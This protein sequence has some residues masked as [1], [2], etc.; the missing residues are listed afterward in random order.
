M[1][2]STIRPALKRTVGHCGR[3]LFF[4]LLLWP[5]VSFA[6]L[7]LPLLDSPAGRSPSGI[8]HV[9]D[10]PIV[11]D[12]IGRRIER[13]LSFGETHSYVL[14]P[15]LDQYV[16]LQLEGFHAEVTIA[17]RL[18]DGR[19]LLV[20]RCKPWTT[21]DLPIVTRAAGTHTVEVRVQETDSHPARYVLTL[22]SL[23]RATASDGFALRAALAQAEAQELSKLWT[24]ETTAKALDKYQRAFRD[25]MTARDPTCAIRC[26]VG[27]TECLVLLGRYQ[28]AKET[29][30]Q[31]ISL[32]RQYNAPR[33]EA[34]ALNGLSA[35]DNIW[36][37][38]DLAL[39]Y[40]NQAMTVAGAAAYREGVARAC[41]NIG[42]A[43]ALAGENLRALESYD[44]AFQIWNNLENLPGVAQTL[45][46][47]GYTHA[48]L[49]E[50]DRAKEC[51]QQALDAWKTLRD[52]QGQAST[53]TAL[54]HLYSILGEKQ[55]ALNLYTQASEIL[56]SLGEP[57]ARASML[58]GL[59]YVYYELD[60]K[61]RA[62]EY[63]QEALRVF[64]SIRYRS[65]EGSSLVW[66]ATCH[67]ALGNHSLAADFLRQALNV[68]EA[69]P[70]TRMQAWLFRVLGEVHHALGDD[71]KALDY[72]RQALDLTVAS[73]NTREQGYILD[74]IADHYFD[75]GEKKRAMEFSLQALELHRMCRDSFG[76]AATLCNLAQAAR[77]LGDLDESLARLQA[78]VGIIES[79]R[80][81]VSVQGLRVSYFASIRRHYD[82]YI[83]LLMRLHS[84]RPGERY[85]AAALQVSERAR[86]RNLLD[87]LSEARA[88]IRSGADPLLLERER[89]LRQALNAKAHQQMQV[90]SRG[91]AEHE[92]EALAKEIGDLNSQLELVE[93]QIR[94]RS[95]RYAALTL[96]LPL[97][98]PQIEQN[99]L[100]KDTLLL[101]YAL[102]DEHSY[103]WAVTTET[104]AG[105]QLPPRMAIEGLARKAYDLLI[106]RQKREAGEPQKLWHRRM[107]ESDSEYWKAASDL[108][109]VLLGPVAAKLGR[110]RLLI[111]SE[112]MLQYLPFAALPVPTPGNAKS[113]NDS[114][115]S[116]RTPLVLEHEIVH[117]PSAST[118]AVL[119]RE[120]DGRKPGEGGVV[121]F[122]DPV[123]EKE[124]PRVEVNKP[125]V[126]R[127]L[128]Q[129]KMPLKAG[130]SSNLSGHVP[131]KSQASPVHAE[132][133]LSRLFSTRRE[134]E[135]VMSVVPP[136]EGATWMDFEADRSRAT[137]LGLMQYRIVHFA[138][139]GIL[140][141]MNPNLSAI[142][143]C[144]VD[145]QGHPKDGLL[146]LHDIYNLRLSAELVVLSAC[147]TALGKNVR[148]EGLIGLVR[149]FM[150]AGA[151]R[152][153]ASLWK[154]DDD[155]TAELMSRFYRKMLQQKMS[156][157]AAL[158]SAQV[159]MQ[160]E[161]RW[162]APY[163]WA[164]F[165]LQGEYR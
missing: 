68:Y 7:L 156:A 112:G 43:H 58:N 100:D 90:L 108:S 4:W 140:D 71:A 75:R 46:D 154:V 72:Y 60:D 141:D 105:Y 14:A 52:R 79:L 47:Y 145:K 89:L 98:L 117:L 147:N 37:A 109:G 21:L 61:G 34:D 76:E 5:H 8:V 99:V 53:L 161:T 120:L 9:Q 151:A 2:I 32:S 19:N 118:L 69:S 11:L 150:Y 133:G 26:L 48:D 164:A 20:R 51:Y 28:E 3:C 24:K 83:D 127:D 86:A 110:K 70:D 1:A 49:W 155:S 42:T 77:D 50:I 122:A 84:L 27:R 23:R 31:I 111:V 144:T 29:Y 40:A 94:V 134:A 63:F 15:G 95:P 91:S 45:L 39:D 148:G 129:S 130:S 107:Q 97:T 113:D 38:K 163:Y 146:R 59:G 157:A 152:I 67:F 125:R 121:V 139:H 106:A 56:Q 131:P 159:E 119:R 96:P 64:R 160:K 25:W 17:I 54:G 126:P 128:T 142:A 87:L 74:C 41:N 55:E 88:G 137:G 153:L 132:L 62:L 138:T 16:Q 35:I 116:R 123:F 78:A 136:G 33:S 162:S 44:R 101:E 85:D 65:G 30:N 92:R 135:A 80:T 103:L 124:D 12:A 36:G 104:I 6:T 66:A 10:A 93:G 81:K 165:V 102:G 114:E 143:L 149:G 82:L 158:R 73:K 18:P 13:D 57:T 115:S 22:K